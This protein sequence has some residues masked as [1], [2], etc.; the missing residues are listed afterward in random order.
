MEKRGQSLQQREAEE[1]RAIDDLLRECQHQVKD[2]ELGRET[3][4]EKKS[5]GH[6][7]P[8]RG[9]EEDGGEGIRT[10]LPM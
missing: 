8:S 1:E 2:Y 9:I 3:I 10:F 6:S 5:E 7:R 4:V